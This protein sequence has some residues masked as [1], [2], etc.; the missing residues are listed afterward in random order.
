MEKDEVS[1][2]SNGPSVTKPNI[3]LP[4]LVIKSSVVI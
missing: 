4:K 2:T 1:S 3:N